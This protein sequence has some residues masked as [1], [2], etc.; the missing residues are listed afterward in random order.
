MP[1]GKGY[2]SDAQR[3]WA[4]TKTGISALGKAS[5]STRDKESKGKNLPE[6]A[7]PKKG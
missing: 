4:H 6:K 3:R 2:D 7:K 1:I 5:V